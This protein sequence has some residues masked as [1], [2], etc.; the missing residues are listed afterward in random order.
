MWVYALFF[1]S[2][3]AVNKIGDEAWTQRADARCLIAKNERLALADYRL[4]D[5]VGPEALFGRAE[6]VDRATDTIERMI[7][8]IRT[9][10]PSVAK[11]QALISLGLADCDRYIADRRG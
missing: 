4:I 7:L 6:L 2:K 3:E 9:T 5:D 10:V 1:A 11:G 8:D